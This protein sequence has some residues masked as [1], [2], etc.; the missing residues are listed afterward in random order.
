MSFADG[1]A[2][3]IKKGDFLSMNG[4]TN[5]SIKDQTTNNG[6]VPVLQIMMQ[7]SVDLSS[8]QFS[9]SEQGTNVSLLGGMFVANPNQ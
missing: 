8:S 3:N 7:G 1:S 6:G 4:G 5:W 9:I 2:T